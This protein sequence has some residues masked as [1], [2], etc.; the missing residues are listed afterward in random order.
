MAPT[1][2]SKTAWR[3]VQ[4]PTRPQEDLPEHFCTIPG[5][6]FSLLPEKFKPLLTFP[7]MRYPPRSASEPSLGRGRGRRGGRLDAKP[8]VPNKERCHGDFCAASVR[9]PASTQDIESSMAPWM[10]QARILCQKE[11]VLSS[12]PAD[13]QPK[14]F[15]VEEL[16]SCLRNGNSGELSLLDVTK[17]QR[18]N[19]RPIVV[20]R[21]VS[22]SIILEA[23]KHPR[24]C[25]WLQDDT[26]WMFDPESAELISAAAKR[27]RED[28]EE[29]GGS[30]SALTDCC[31][32]GLR[33]RL[34]DVPVC[35]NCFK[36]YSVLQSV[37]DMIR[38]RKRDLWAK[39]ELS[40]RSAEVL[41]AR[42]RLKDEVFEELQERQRT[43][44][45]DLDAD[46]E[47]PGEHLEPLGGAYRRRSLIF[48]P[49]IQEW[50]RQAC[51]VQPPDVPSPQ[52]RHRSSTKSGSAALRRPSTSA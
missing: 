24:L 1:S 23:R 28:E 5:K 27:F 18:T 33:F 6:R 40:R 12:F 38:W 39:Q 36:V 43:R 4:L 41:A 46:Q 32:G 16:V 31:S 2:P 10:T 21:S 17:D 34:R 51:L 20:K 48:E 22:V 15:H 14:L 19:C 25:G 49:H 50:I 8:A 26:G 44:R 29:N 13:K 37:I 3:T 30:V 9:Y 45:L 52:E 11:L 47:G 35:E 42:Q 7:P